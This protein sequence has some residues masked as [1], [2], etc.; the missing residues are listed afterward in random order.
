MKKLSTLIIITLFT[1]A[2][3]GCQNDDVGTTKIY[4]PFSADQ[5]EYVEMFRYTDD[6]TSAE[7]KIVTESDTIRYLHG[8]FE[9]LSVEVL[10]EQPKADAAAVTA[11]RFYLS[12]STEETFEIIYYGYGVKNGVLKMPPNEIYYFTSA[13]IGWNW[14][15][16]DTEMEAIPANENELPK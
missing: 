7:K 2:V 13:D 12:N 10:N 6:T 15:E 1:L 5:I 16:L 8:A 11:F 4:L 3:C 14:S 9:Q